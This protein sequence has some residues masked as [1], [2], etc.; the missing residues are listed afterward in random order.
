MQYASFFSGD[1]HE[2]RQQF[3]SAL[4]AVEFSSATHEI[5]AKDSAG[6]TLSIDVGIGGDLESD[7][8]LII[9]SGVHGVEGLFGSAV[10]LAFLQELAVGNENRSSRLATRII[11]IHAVNPYGFAWQR[12]CNEDN[13]D[14][15]R[16]FLL[17]GE[18]YTGS[19]TNY[20][21]L[22]SFVNP[23]SPPPRFDDFFL[24]AIIF[25]LKYGQTL[26]KNTLPVGQYDYPKGLFFG[27]K[28]PSQSQQIF[29]QNL[30]QWVGDATEIVHLDFHTGLGKWATYKLL[31]DGDDRS[32]CYDRL[33]KQFGAENIE[34][35][36]SMNT[37]STSYPIRGGLGAWC[38]ATLSDRR[39]DFF[40]AEF[41]TYSAAR[42]LQA[43]RTE[44]RA[45]WWQQPRLS[46]P[47]FQDTFVPPNLQW[48]ESCL[49]QALDI[50]RRSSH[51]RS[52]ALPVA[53]PAYPGV[54]E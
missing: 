53:R 50:C 13:I 16:N 52:D 28:A 3:L 30:T 41:G 11:L 4:D 48:R 8:A 54:G 9:S 14:L 27:G 24:K 51:S 23:I 17:P 7:R 49:R 34:A 2:S 37:N 22:D 31:W 21:E 42:V 10:Q 19:P 43:L 38:K 25:I 44:N 33:A 32:P 45:Y 40:T 26:L 15:N 6:E 1:Y 29:A 39:Y 46:N 20:A 18:T 47:Q 12:R 36:Q 35:K 5:A